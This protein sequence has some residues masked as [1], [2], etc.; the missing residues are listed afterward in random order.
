MKCPQCG[1]DNPEDALFCGLCG[2]SLGAS[3]AGVPTPQG[4]VSFPGA[5]KL[6][7]QGYFDFRSRSTRAEYWWWLLF[8]GVACTTAGLIDTLL[9]Q[10]FVLYWIF[11]LG[12]FVAH[13]AVSVRRLH[14]TNKTGWWL[15]LVFVPF[16]GIVLWV[17]Y[18]Q[19]S[20][21]GTNKYGPNPQGTNLQQ[22]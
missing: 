3:I 5:V 11:A 1:N 4:M 16:G 12:L 20:D 17:F 21:M 7:F 6:A 18:V 15:L 13:W 2:T 10:T 22:P 9:W 8:Q 19:A 14:D